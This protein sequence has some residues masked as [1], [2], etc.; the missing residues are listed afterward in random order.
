MHSNTGKEYVI[1]DEKCTMYMGGQEAQLTH[2]S[3]GCPP[4]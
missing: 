2:L 3:R 1:T 4:S